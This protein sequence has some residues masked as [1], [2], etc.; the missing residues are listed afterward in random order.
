MLSILVE[1]PLLPFL[2]LFVRSLDVISLHTVTEEGQVCLLSSETQ[3]PQ[4]EIGMSALALFG[5]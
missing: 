4:M 1:G 5:Q 3:R 2:Q